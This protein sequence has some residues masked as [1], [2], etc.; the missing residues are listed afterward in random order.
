MNISPLAKCHHHHLPRSTKPSQAFPRL[1]PPKS[2]KKFK[3]TSPSSYQVHDVVS[4]I[5][6]EKFLQEAVHQGARGHV[7]PDDDVTPR[8]LLGEVT[9]PATS[10]AEK[11]M[12]RRVVVLE[13]GEHHCLKVQCC[14]RLGAGNRGNPPL[15]LVLGVLAACTH[16][17]LAAEVE[18]MVELVQ[19]SRYHEEEEPHQQDDRHSGLCVRRADVAVSDRAARTKGAATKREGSPRSDA[20]SQSRAR[21]TNMCGWS[22]RAMCCGT[23]GSAPQ[24]NGLPGSGS[25]TQ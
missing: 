4:V 19:L 15:G 21:K 1:P 23:Y 20:E 2:Q 6:V 18:Q 7:A 10:V 16:R 17:V 22:S 5:L 3:V 11:Q 12:A 14:T 25:Q 8:K 24:C 13:R 9:L